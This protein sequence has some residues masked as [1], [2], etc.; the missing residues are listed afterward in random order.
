MITT[1]RP[2]ILEQLRASIAPLSVDRVLDF[3][4]GD[5]Y[6][7]S[8]V[9]KLP[10][11]GRL[12]PVDVVARPG[13]FVK[14]QLYDGARLPFDDRSFELSYAVDVLHHC[15]E[16]IAAIDDMARCSSRYLL[17]KDHTFR[18][19]AGKYVLAVLDE[20][21]NRR[22][23][24]PSPYRYQRDWQWVEHIEA[25]GWKRLQMIHP[26]ACHTGPLSLTNGLQWMGLWERQAG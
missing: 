7:A 15:P 1:Y 23:G 26:M 14:A 10:H 3:G 11:V 24:I 16:P 13:S 20:L 4:C 8:K 5:G 19:I 6:F 21:G 9:A 25:R 17:I 2:R 22:F 12:V 18:T